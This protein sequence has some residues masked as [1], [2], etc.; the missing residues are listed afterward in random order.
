MWRDTW[1]GIANMMTPAL[2]AKYG[3]KLHYI[4]I[5]QRFK[6]NIDTGSEWVAYNLPPSQ[7]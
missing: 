6:S 1:P 2:S 5:A 4:A 7:T 3:F